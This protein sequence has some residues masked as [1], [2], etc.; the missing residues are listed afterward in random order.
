MPKNTA[1]RTGWARRSAASVPEEI[2]GIDPVGAVPPLAGL[3]PAV[4]RPLL[5]AAHHQRVQCGGHR[6]P[7]HPNALRRLGDLC[8]EQRLGRGGGKRRL[9]SEHLVG[10]RTERIE[11]G[12]MIDVGIGRGLLGRHVGGGAQRHS[13]RGE[14]TLPRRRRDRLGHAEVGDQG[15]PARDHHIVGL[16]VTMDHAFG[17]GVSE[18]VAHFAEDPDSLPHRQLALAHQLGPE[19]FALDVGHHVVEDIAGGAGGEQ[20][21][22][23]RVLQPGGQLDLAAEPV[24]VDA[25]RHLGRED[26]DDD[27]AAELDFV[28]QEDAAHAPAT[29]LL[30]DPVRRA[31]GRVETGAQ[32]A[33]R[34][35]TASRGAIIV[36]RCR[37]TWDCARAAGQSPGRLGEPAPPA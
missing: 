20:R 6:G 18:R 23:V 22:D 11:V 36:L 34:I 15:M 7:P 28:R 33:H 32:I 17:V 9:T 31:E 13:E 2:G 8:G 19:R 10:H 1:T 35:P 3:L 16:D 14:A 4:G 5:Q 30:L 29:E 27:L 25:G 26:L 21:H 37:G 24:L 12:P